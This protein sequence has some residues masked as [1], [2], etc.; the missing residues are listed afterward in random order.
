[1]DTK[2]NTLKGINTP[3]GINQDEINGIPW[4][5]CDTFRGGRCGGV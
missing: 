3:K 1:M 2:I 5:A 4:K